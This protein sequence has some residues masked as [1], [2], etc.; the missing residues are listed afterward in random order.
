YKR[1]LYP[2]YAR[3]SVVLAQCGFAEHPKATP[4]PI[5][6]T[7][8]Q[9]SDLVV[10][11]GRSW[12][13]TDKF[14][15][16]LPADAGTGALPQLSGF[17]QGAQ[18]GNRKLMPHPIRF[19]FVASRP[20]EA[21]FTIAQVARSGG[22]ITLAVNGRQVAERAWPAS[23]RDRTVSETIVAPFSAGA[24]E[25]TV[26]NPGVD[27]VTLD[28]VKIPGIG[29][30]ALAVCVRDLGYTLARIQWP[31]GFG[32]RPRTVAL[33]GLLNGRYRMKQFDLD[34]GTS[35]TTHLRITH[36]RITSYEP[37]GKDE[38]LA[39]WREQ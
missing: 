10:R 28:S 38:G 29:P 20:G 6:V 39:L 12:A 17:L 32:S 30:G 3:E 16:E 2:E 4:G 34:R 26:D 36:G 23:D 27:W 14:V 37:Y 31:N 15:Y 22:E 1:N 25:I 21:V 5:Q 13:A 7:G 19:R 18:S 9:P 24:N 8:G 11:P 33:P 35:K